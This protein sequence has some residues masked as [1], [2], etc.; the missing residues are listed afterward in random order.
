MA[1]IGRA[2]G[3]A[4]LLIASA[5]QED[6]GHRLDPRPLMGGWFPCEDEDCT[7][8]GGKGLAFAGDGWFFQVTASAG[9]VPEN[10]LQIGLGKKECCWHTE[11]D[12]LV[13]D[14]RDTWQELWFR[15]LDDDRLQIE[16]ARSTA[17]NADT[18]VAAMETTECREGEEFPEPDTDEDEEDW[19]PAAWTPEKCWT[20]YWAPL[21]R[22][23]RVVDPGAMAVLITESGL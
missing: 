12:H 16:L 7:A 6:D 10:P 19:D 11:S 1:G 2:T 3:L 17:F 18:E 13:V 21:G 15:F 20:E 9:P 8:I 22:A 5:C 23:I 14:L 4:L